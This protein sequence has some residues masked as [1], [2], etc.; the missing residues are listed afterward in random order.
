MSTVATSAPAPASAALAAVPA[1]TRP[2]PAAQ[3]RTIF[4]IQMARL[5]AAWSR[6]VIVASVM[7]LGIGLVIRAVNGR[8]PAEV[9]L[10]IVAGEVL[11]AVTLTSVTNLAQRMAVMREQGA[12]DYYATLPIS[13]GALLAAVFSSYLVFALPGA[14]I[15]YL[16]SVPLFHLHYVWNPLIAI[17]VL[18]GSFS[19]AG[20]G[21]WIGLL[22]GDE[23]LASMLANLVM[24]SVLFLG[25]VAPAHLPVVLRTARWALPSTYAVQGVRD[26]MAGTNTALRTFGECAAMLGFTALFAPLAGRAMNWRRRG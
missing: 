4:R 26:T 15:V 12:F 9:A 20:L 24:M 7:P 8:P 16:V 5:R 23:Q 21:A 22:A 19:L 6:Y 11:L 13:R 25:I 3:Y 18:L 2:G 14:A 17:L 1:S 10:Q